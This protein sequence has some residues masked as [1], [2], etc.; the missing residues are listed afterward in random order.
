MLRPSRTP[1]QSQNLALCL[2]LR[3]LVWQSQVRWAAIN[4]VSLLRRH[5]EV[6]DRCACVCVCDEG[7]VQLCDIYSRTRTHSHVHVH[8]CACVHV[9]SLRMHLMRRDHLMV[10]MDALGFRHSTTQ[11]P[12]LSF[13]HLFKLL[14]PASTLAQSSRSTTLPLPPSPFFAWAQPNF[15]SEKCS[16]MATN[17]DLGVWGLFGGVFS[18]AHFFLKLCFAGHFF[19]QL[20]DFGPARPLSE[21]VA[22]F[23]NPLLMNAPTSSRKTNPTGWRHWRTP[24]LLD[25]VAKWETPKKMSDP[26]CI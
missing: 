12:R 10:I 5:K 18:F 11:Q 3:P 13:I 6:H 20:S 23:C 26:S 16:K 15:F 7:C 21:I 9:R 1:N 24:R 8:M 25:I 4:T 2:C 17:G 19:A 22:M 14:Q